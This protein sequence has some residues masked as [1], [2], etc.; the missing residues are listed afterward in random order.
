MSMARQKGMV[1]IMIVVTLLSLGMYALKVIAERLEYR[2]EISNG[3]K[4]SSDIASI[5]SSWEDSMNYA[6]SSGLIPTSMSLSDLSLRPSYFDYGRYSFRYTAPPNSSVTVEVMAG[7]TE[8][9]AA[10]VS[11]SKAVERM[12]IKAQI[13][14]EK[15]ADDRIKVTATRL[16]RTSQIIFDT[17]RQNSNASTTSIIIDGVQLYDSNGC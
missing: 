7:R 11:V 15:V 17:F 16:T 8:L 9:A 3:G 4:V 5:I 14:V 12:H 1:G 6:C 13:V 10:I 2:S